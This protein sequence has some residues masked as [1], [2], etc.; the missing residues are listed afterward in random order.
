[1]NVFLYEKLL[2]Q[3]TELW[4]NSTLFMASDQEHSSFITFVSL[5]DFGF[6]SKKTVAYHRKLNKIGE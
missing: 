4:H 6:L 5:K 2:N 3:Y 1:M